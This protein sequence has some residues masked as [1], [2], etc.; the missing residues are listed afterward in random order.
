[1]TQLFK[2]KV[3]FHLPLHQWGTRWKRK[4]ICGINTTHTL[5]LLSGQFGSWEAGSVRR[6]TSFAP[7]L[8]ANHYLILGTTLLTAKLDSAIT[9]TINKQNI[10]RMHAS[11]SCRNTKVSCEK[12]SF[13]DRNT[14]L[15]VNRNGGKTFSISSWKCHCVQ[16]GKSIKFDYQ[17]V[18]YLCPPI[19]SHHKRPW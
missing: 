19:S 14:L 12:K 5:A 7:C 9:S 10:F 2:Q 13:L 16:K 1:M 6:D 17:N 11:I 15:F 3:L 8:S 4:C 18:K